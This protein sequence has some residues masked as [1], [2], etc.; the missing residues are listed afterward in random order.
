MTNKVLKPENW[1]KDYAPEPR[2]K[3][4]IANQIAQAQQKITEKE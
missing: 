3:Q 4:E 2:I 1:E